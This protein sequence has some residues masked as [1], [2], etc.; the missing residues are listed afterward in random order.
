MRKLCVILN[1]Q[2]S[3]QPFG[4]GL[5]RFVVAIATT[6]ARRFSA[7]IS[8]ILASLSASTEADEA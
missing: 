6:F 4:W 3:P 5:I 2:S 1:G 8:L 7:R